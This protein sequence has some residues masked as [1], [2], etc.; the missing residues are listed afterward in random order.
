MLA[1]SA[2]FASVAARLP[3]QNAIL[4]IAC[5][6]ASDAVVSEAPAIWKTLCRAEEPVAPGNCFQ[7]VW[8]NTVTSKIYEVS[9]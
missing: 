6:T 3:L 1:S 8:D 9:S 2:Y 7:E 5:S 4:A